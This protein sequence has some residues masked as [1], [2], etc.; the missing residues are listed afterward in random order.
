[1]DTTKPVISIL[2]AVRNDERFIAE[3][4]A[5][6]A[7]Q[8]YPNLELIIMDGAS[9]DR[10]PEIVREY[11]ATHPNVIFRSEP[12]S[13]QWD[14][15]EKALALST[16]EYV[17]LLCG[18]D[19]YLDPDWFAKCIEAF[20]AHPEVSLVWGIPFNMS[21]DGKLVGPHYAYAGFLR[22]KRYGAQTKPL[23]TLTAKIDW[24]RPGAFRRMLGMARKL[25][26]PRLATVVGSFRKSD[27]PQKKNWFKY[28][29]STGRAF[30]EG[31]M[32]VRRE[33]YMANTGRFPHETMTNSALL[34]FIFNFN[35][36]G[37]LAYGL[38]V[39]A[40]FGRHH[41]VGQ[42]LR[43]HD[44]ALVKK[45]E[46]KISLFKKESKQHNETRLMHAAPMIISRT[47]FRISFFGGGTDYPA[48][49][50][51]NGGATL[52]T[53]IDKYS[54]ITARHYPPFFPEKYR[55]VYSRIEAV[56]EHHE[57]E[58]PSVR[59]VLKHLDIRDGVEIHNAADLPARSGLGSSSAFTVG[60]LSALYNLTDRTT[61]KHAL[62]MDA[63]HVEQNLI[64]ENVGSQDQVAAAFGGFNKITFGPG[65]GISVRP[66][67]IEKSRLETLNGRLMLFFTGFSRIASEVAVEWIKN[68]P[69]KEKE[70]AVMRAM[71][72][73][74]V[75]ILENSTR[76]I[77]DFGRLLHEGWLIK[78]GLNHVV[79]TD[80]IDQVYDRARKAGA[81]GGKLL[82]AGQGGFM[83]IYA[84]PDFQQHV[85]QALAE[86]LEVPFKFENSGSTIVQGKYSSA[87]SD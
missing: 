62:A 61:T 30:P 38:P 55:V 20:T 86:L 60:L 70:L 67:R 37:Y 50:E 29:L 8:T 26:G 1:M 4:L 76:D 84:H 6:V 71:V 85:R 10:T 74:G 81:I 27:I 47:P 13:G 64:H 34:D 63:I 12:D 19:G 36:R 21:E 42:A 77:D 40:S 44:A 48:W 24:R 66:V 22:D 33:V 32:C 9:T 31:N 11:A 23:G 41:A 17:T 46:E 54:Y 2:C 57:I 78:R 73:Q 16:G 28:W 82:G 51:K 68:V 75:E 83:L 25:T 45:Y 56:N 15:L 3:T 87:A 79:T 18:Q 39:A 5:S 52:S 53:T 80:H 58:H 35:I 14:A 59:E 49:Y 43:E 69:N 65:K 7:A 72:D